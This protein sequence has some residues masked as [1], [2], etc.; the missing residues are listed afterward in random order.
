M[1]AKE[2]FCQGNM[3]KVVMD[4]MFQKVVIYKY[5]EFYLE[6]SEKYNYNS[7]T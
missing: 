3:T 6:Q 7:Q 1:I 5:L 4:A 2:A